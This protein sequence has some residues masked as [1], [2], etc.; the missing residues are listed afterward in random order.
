MLQ[1]VRARPQGTGLAD[2][3]VAR[4]V[5]RPSGIGRAEIIGARTGKAAISI[6]SI[7]SISG[8]SRADRSSANRSSTDAQRRR[9]R[10]GC[11]TIDAGAGYA[12]A[13]AGASNAG[14]MNAAASHASAGSSLG[15]GHEQ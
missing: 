7:K 8:S 5:V 6:G 2:K 9:T 14:V 12:A 4:R 1:A 11:T 15:G 3:A 13:I 10:D